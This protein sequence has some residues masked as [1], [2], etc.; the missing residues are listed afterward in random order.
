[1]ERNI[2]T[3]QAPVPTPGV[4][5]PWGCASGACVNVTTGALA[6]DVDGGMVPGVEL[7]STIEGNDGFVKYTNAEW[8][9]FVADVKAGVWDHTVTLESVN[10]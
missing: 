6:R 3:P 4:V 1:M 9:K 5:P 7:T 8:A 2:T 10:A